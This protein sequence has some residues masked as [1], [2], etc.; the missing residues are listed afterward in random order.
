MINLLYPEN[1]EPSGRTISEKTAESLE[2]KYIAMLIC[3]YNTDFALK[4]LTELV[5]DEDVTVWRQD[6]LPP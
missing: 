5:T 6:I 3:P 2:L 4:V 1:Y